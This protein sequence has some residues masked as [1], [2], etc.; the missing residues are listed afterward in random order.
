[1]AKK[2]A[3]KP[4]IVKAKAIRD[5]L[6]A[7]PGEQPKDIALRLTEEGLKVTA[8]EVSNVKS[9]IKRAAGGR[10]PAPKSAPTGVSASALSAAECAVPEDMVSVKNLEKVKALASELGGIAQLRCNLETL[11]KLM[12]WRF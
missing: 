4:K 11:E 2:K 1:M 12:T 6:G 9:Q 5:A 8:Q 3:G 10:L 7:F